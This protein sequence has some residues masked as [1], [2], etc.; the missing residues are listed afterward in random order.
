MRSA[1]IVRRPLDVAAVSSSVSSDSNGAVALFLGTVRSTNDGRPVTGIE[2]TAYDEMAEKEMTTI[3]D[4]A[5]EKFG[6][7]DLRIEHRVGELTIGEASIAVAAAHP[8]RKPALDA[9]RYIVEETK[10]RA[11]IW[12]LELYADG[13]REWVNAGSRQT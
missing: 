1:S 12:K 6:V 8:H 9:L 10:A 11:P 13:T 3:L 2:Y 5:A 4:E 7:S